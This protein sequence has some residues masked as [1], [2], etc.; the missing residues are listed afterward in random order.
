ML[1]K[2]SFPR[3]SSLCPH[4]PPNCCPSSHGFQPLFSKSVWKNAQTLLVGALLAIGKRTVTAC[5]R[6][7]GK[8]ADKHCQNFHRVLNRAQWSALTASRLLLRLLVSTFA[9]TGE[10]VFGLDDTIERRRGEKIKAKGIYRDPVRSSKS[11]FVKASGLR[12]LSCMLLH[13]VPWA[14]TVWG[15]PFLTVLCPSERYYAEQKRQ[16]QKLTE[17]AWQMIALVARWLPDRVLVFVTDSSF[18]A[19]VLLDKVRRL[20]NVSLITRLRMDA[21]LYDFAPERKPG[22]K[23]RPRLKGA[24]R[25]APQERLEDPETKWK[26]IKVKDWYGGGERQ[27]E[28]YSETCLWG[29]T[30]K[31]YVPLRWVLVRDVLGEFEPCAFLST[32]LT[33]K[34]L[35]M[36]TWF[37][38]R[39]RMEVTFEEARAHL[40]IETQR[41]WNELAIARST[42]VLFGLFSLV[43]L[44]ANA[45]SK[46]QA[47]VVRTAAWYAKEQ[48]TFSDALGLVRRCLWSSCHFQ[49]SNSEAD[50]VKIPRSLF[51]RLT[52]AVCYAA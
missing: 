43:A 14:G 45:L 16:H 29:T 49:M 1:L 22:Q 27:V 28:V 39:W 26:K 34:P 18:A 21:Q 5:L 6:V 38:R 32:E 51:E 50:I 41:Q 52:D 47:K 23:G 36:L 15:L 20:K 48:P 40:G 25:P 31:P 2:I 24:R 7:M 12:W 37:V 3:E 4:C 13:S 33:H 17:R 46:D 19:F 35:Q 44:M 10:L 9:P 30:G 11:H 8:S 42:P